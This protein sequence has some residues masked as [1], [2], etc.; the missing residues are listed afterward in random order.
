MPEAPPVNTSQPEQRRTLLGQLG[1]SPF[2][3][4]PPQAGGAQQLA[5]TAG[6][7]QSLAGQAIAM[8]F[9]KVKE[10]HLSGVAPSPNRDPAEIPEESITILA[11]GEPP[12]TSEMLRRSVA[13]ANE[14]IGGAMPAQAQRDYSAF[15]GKTWRDGNAGLIRMQLE[16]IGMYSEDRADPEWKPR[17]KAL[18]QS[19][20]AH[21]TGRAQ[22]GAARMCASGHENAPGNRFCGICGK[23][24]REAGNE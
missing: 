15:I 5:G 12:L 2:S 19:M 24:V 22:T 10:I 14:L 13:V 8:I 1:L 18:F 17:A 4:P 20:A 3:S 7:V 9:D 16:F 11:S 21:A 6:V 23:P